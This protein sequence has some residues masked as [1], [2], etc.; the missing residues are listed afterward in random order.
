V[1]RRVGVAAEVRV[2]PALA[3][4]SDVPALVGD[5]ARLRALGWAPTRD[6]DAIIDDLIHAASH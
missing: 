6:V 5:S 1:L 3:R 2:D 4:P